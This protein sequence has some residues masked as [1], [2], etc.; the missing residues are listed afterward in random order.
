VAKFGISA[1]ITLI[2]RTKSNS[3]LIRLSTHD[4]G[5]F[6]TDTAFSFGAKPEQ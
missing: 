3:Q 6:G 4:L 5:W 1:V 2:F